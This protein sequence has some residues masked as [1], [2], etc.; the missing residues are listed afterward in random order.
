MIR[1]IRNVIYVGPLVIAYSRGGLMGYRYRWRHLSRISTRFKIV[2]NECELCLTK[3]DLH[4][5]DKCVCFK[6]LPLP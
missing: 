3:R 6:D 5:R 4:G 2:R 1:R